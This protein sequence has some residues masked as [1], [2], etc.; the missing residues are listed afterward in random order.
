MLLDL[1]RGFDRRNPDRSRIPP[2]DYRNRPEWRALRSVDLRA[3]RAYIE[4]SLPEHSR[5]AES[6]YELG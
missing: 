4:S 1:D 2:K 6:A 5:A 3:E